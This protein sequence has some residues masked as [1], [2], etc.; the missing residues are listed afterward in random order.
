[1]ICVVKYDDA[2]VIIPGKL[3][4]MNPVIRPAGAPQK[5]V[6]FYLGSMRTWRVPASLRNPRTLKHDI[7]SWSGDRGMTG[8]GS[9]LHAKVTCSEYKPSCPRLS[10]RRLHPYLHTYAQFV[11]SSHISQ[12]SLKNLYR[13]VTTKTTDPIIMHSSLASIIMAAA[14]LHQ[15]SAF[16]GFEQNE[17]NGMVPVADKLMSLHPEIV[18]VL[19]STPFLNALPALDKR[20]DPV[21][22]DG[23]PDPNRQVVTP[24]NVYVLQCTEPGFRGN[25]LVFGAAPGKCA[26]YYDFSKDPSFLAMYDNQTSSIST[27]TGGECQFYK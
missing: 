16:T 27:N 3:S 6:Q 17:M 25:C 12:L 23:Q 19:Q 1:M 15:A 2:A 5:A 10:W 7:A 26:N 4:T 9:Q 22:V 8:A 18:P 14:T 24:Q 20:E 13:S 11:Q 21:P